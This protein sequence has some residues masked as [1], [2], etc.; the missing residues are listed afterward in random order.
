MEYLGW[1]AAS[2]LLAVIF[3]VTYAACECL[4]DFFTRKDF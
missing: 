3:A 2:A 4:R 1:F